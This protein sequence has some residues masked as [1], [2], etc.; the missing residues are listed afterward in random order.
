MPNPLV[1]GR[2]VRAFR[3]P[4]KEE[5]GDVGFHILFREK[6]RKASAREDARPR[7]KGSAL[8]LPPA[9]G[10]ETLKEEGKRG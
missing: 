1:R 8:L 2:G 9:Q 10:R 3:L 5:R 6:K 4:R 7:E